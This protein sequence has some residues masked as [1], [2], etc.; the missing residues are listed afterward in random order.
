MV[1]QRQLAVT[2]LQG[3][4]AWV[5][6][7]HRIAAALPAG[8]TVTTTGPHSQPTRGLVRGP[9]RSRRP[10]TSPY[11]GTIAITG[12][13]I[14]G[15]KSVSAVIDALSAVRG[16]GAVWVPNTTKSAATPDG[17]ATV[18][19]SHGPTVRVALNRG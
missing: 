17:T 6:L 8:V 16:I 12:K 3:D 15:P 7:V 13:T 11:V 14:N 1:A 4:I 19:V 9:G 5:S 18:R 2:A 10:P